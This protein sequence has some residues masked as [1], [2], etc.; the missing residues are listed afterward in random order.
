[1]LELR[2]AVAAALSAFTL[3][4]GR[5]T[6]LQQPTCER[7]SDAVSCVRVPQTAR[8]FRIWAQK[9]RGKKTKTNFPESFDN[10]TLPQK[11][12]T[13]LK[14]SSDNDT[15]EK[16]RTVRGLKTKRRNWCVEC[17]NCEKREGGIHEV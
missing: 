12:G 9:Q 11:Q 6:S 4:V 10:H 3:W 7:D 15:S 17:G 16:T 2:G 14:A 8:I 13:A 5:Q 1:L